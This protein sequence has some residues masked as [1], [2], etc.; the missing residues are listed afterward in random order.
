MESNRKFTEREISHT[1]RVLSAHMCRCF[2]GD[3]SVSLREVEWFAAGSQIIITTFRGYRQC[4]PFAR[5]G[6]NV[7]NT[8][9][10]LYFN[11]EKKNHATFNFTP[12]QFS[13]TIYAILINIYDKTN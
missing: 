9:I 7:L 13:W 12:I 1:L 4:R 11:E 8:M 10:V 6:L 5:T 2:V 3:C